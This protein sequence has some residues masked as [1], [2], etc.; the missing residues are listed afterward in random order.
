MSI[1]PNSTV[2]FLSGVPLDNTY[3]HTIYFPDTA[4]QYSY[5]AGNF[6]STTQTHL[7][8]Q[9]VNSNKIRVQIPADTLYSYNYMLFKNTTYND[10][11]FYAFIVS[12]SYINDAVCEV[13]YEIDVMQT[14]LPNIAYNLASCYIERQHT[15][16]DNWY[17]HTISE[18][19]DIGTGYICMR[20][21][22]FNTGADKACILYTGPDGQPT[23]IGR[24]NDVLVTINF[25][26][27]YD[28][29]DIETIGDVI[30]NIGGK[31]ILAIYQY[32]AFM[33]DEHSGTASMDIMPYTGTLDGYVPKNKKL[34]CYPYNF[35]R[36]SNNLGEIAD[37]RWEF[38]DS[39]DTTTKSFGIKGTYIT[40]PSMIC[41]PK[42]YKGL[43]NDYEDGLVYSNFPVCPVVSNAF[44]TWWGNNKNSFILG[45]VASAISAISGGVTTGITSDPMAGAVQAISGVTATTLNSIGKLEDMKVQ[46]ASVTGKITSDTLNS[47]LERIGYTFY[48]LCLKNEYAKIVDDYFERFGYAI[49]R[50]SVPNIHA[51]PCWTY[52]QTIGCTIN[53]DK[54]SNEDMHKIC[55]IYNKGITFW[56][57]TATVG[58]YTQ[59]NTV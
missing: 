16:T 59:D 6:T 37:Y 55:G 40:A 17:E 36:V 12:V 54:L 22:P 56:V 50:N 42:A 2:K 7:T 45:N 20:Q 5:F 48:C 28:I 32:P 21:E 15:T 3:E 46:E 38:F 53:S 13:E 23:S 34:Y 25:S 57:H 10:K 39:H 47:K 49:K 33:S 18:N 30:Q 8:Y 41:Y 58:D 4:T 26:A 11:W 31:N 52:V 14:W 29:S 27:N 24:F 9:R 35:L 44:E 19:I 1:A 51:R 43:S